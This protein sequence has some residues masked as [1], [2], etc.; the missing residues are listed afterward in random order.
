MLVTTTE[1]AIKREARGQSYILFSTKNKRK[2]NLQVK[3]QT[4]NGEEKDQKR[5]TELGSNFT[6]RVHNF[7]DNNQVEDQDDKTNK[8][9]TVREH[10]IEHFVYIKAKRK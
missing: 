7:K 2:K 5:P 10:V 1:E 8:A 9:T 4:N 3:N 6:V